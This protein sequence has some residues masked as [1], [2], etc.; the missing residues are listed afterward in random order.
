MVY[1]DIRELTLATAAANVTND[2]PMFPRL[3]T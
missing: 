3:M 2:N 1:G